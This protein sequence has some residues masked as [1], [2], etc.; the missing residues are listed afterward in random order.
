[1]QTA[2]AHCSALAPCNQLLLPFL[3]NCINYEVEND[4]GEGSVLDHVTSCAE[5]A[6]IEPNGPATED[7]V[8][9]KAHNETYNLLV[10]AHIV[11]ALEAA[12]L[13]HRVVSLV[14][15]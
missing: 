6:A 4:W 15:I 10:D 3:H 7:T 5:D 9:S 14:E 11:Q 1:M 13:I 8:L 12:A 2:A